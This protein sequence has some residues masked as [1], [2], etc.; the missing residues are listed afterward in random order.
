MSRIELGMR[1]AREHDS[2]VTVAYATLPG[3][4]LVPLAPDLGAS[5]LQALRD[6]DELRVREARKGFDRVGTRTQV[7][8][9]WIQCCDLPVES[10][11]VRQALYADLLVLGQ[12]DP[13]DAEAGWMPPAFVEYAIAAGG[14]PVLVVPH[15]VPVPREFG[16]V[17]IAWKETRE[18]AR[19]VAAALPFLERAR[20]VVALSWGTDDALTRNALDRLAAYLRSH[21]VNGIE[22]RPQADEGPDTGELLL[23]RAADF[24]AELLVMGCYGHGRV[25]EW[26]LGGVSRTILRS[27]TLPVLLAH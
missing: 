13:G 26:V 7:P 11:F 27:M 18:A 3:Y 4:A 23:S 19:A 6:F 1:I 20:R 5:A 9:E 24:G 22:T 21:G 15:S 14:K 8:A 17:L 25:R 10:E 12:E 2:A 16:T